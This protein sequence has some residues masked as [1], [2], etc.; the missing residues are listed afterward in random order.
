MLSISLSYL[1]NSQL[2]MNFFVDCITWLRYLSISILRQSFVLG[3]FFFHCCFVLILLKLGMSGEK[4][5]THATQ[6]FC[7]VFM[8][9]VFWFIWTQ[10][11]FCPILCDIYRPDIRRESKKKKWI[12]PYIKH[13]KRTK[14]GTINCVFGWFEYRHSG[15]DCISVPLSLIYTCI[16]TGNSE[17]W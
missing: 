10:I 8:A 2:E 1:F 17:W 11:A 9:G 15:L 12:K 13:W 16:Q 5:P 6:F 3:V 4:W 7:F 14:N